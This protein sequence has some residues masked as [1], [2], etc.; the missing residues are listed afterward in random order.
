MNK[1]KRKLDQLQGRSFAREVIAFLCRLHLGGTLPKLASVF[2]K[3]KSAF[4]RVNSTPKRKQN[5][6]LKRGDCDL[7]GWKHQS[8]TL[9][10][11]Q[12]DKQSLKIGKS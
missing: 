3:A 5:R 8:K 12:A 2:G 11:K 4:T 9:I 1:A 7:K 6:T 10:S